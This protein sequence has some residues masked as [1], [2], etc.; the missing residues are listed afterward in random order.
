LLPVL[1][2]VVVGA[3]VAL[4]VPVEAPVGGFVGLVSA[5]TPDVVPLALLAALPSGRWPE[6][7]VL[8]VPGGV[9]ALAQITIAPCK[10]HVTRSTRKKRNMIAPG[11]VH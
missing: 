2:P 6:G 5:P 11:G 10:M 4:R 7:G 9:W 1:A 8:G 3:F